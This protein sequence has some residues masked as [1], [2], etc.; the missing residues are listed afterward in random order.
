[1]QKRTRVLG[2]GTRRHI[3]T[4]AAAGAVVIVCLMATAMYPHT[5]SSVVHPEGFVLEGYGRSAPAVSTGAA[6]PTATL[7]TLATINAS[8]SRSEQRAVTPRGAALVTPNSAVV[9]A[10]SQVADGMYLRLAANSQFDALLADYTAQSFIFGTAYTAYLGVDQVY[11]GFDWSANG[12]SHTTYW[13][14]NIGNQ[15]L[16]GPI[17]QVTPTIYSS[18]DSVNWAGYEWHVTSPSTPLAGNE[19]DELV[20]TISVPPQQP[21]N[22][23]SGVTVDAADAVWLGLSGSAG[24][25]GG[26]L[27]TGYER[28]ATQNWPYAEWYEFYPNPQYDYPGSPTVSPGDYAWQAMNTVSFESP[29]WYASVYD[30]TKGVGASVT[31]NEGSWLPYYFQGIT[32]AYEHNGV[33][34]Q[35]AEFSQTSFYDLYVCSYNESNCWTDIYPGANSVLSMTTYQLRQ[36]SGVDNTNYGSSGGPGGEFGTYGYTYVTWSTSAYNFDYIY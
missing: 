24:G 27:Q 32:E 25:N 11:F 30:F 19:G 4:L 9:Q 6:A 35:I 18:T 5:A 15:S 13:T 17:D 20:P 10:K 22:V 29:E 28:D 3:P 36:S 14:G 33:I 12:S 7:L 1:M 26:L 34:Q 31:L 21:S 23:P 16:T 8:I 2:F